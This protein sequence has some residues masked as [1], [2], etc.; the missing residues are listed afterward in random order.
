MQINQHEC[1]DYRCD[2]NKEEEV[3]HDKD[4]RVRFT[5]HDKTWENIVR[6]VLFAVGHSQE[7][8]GI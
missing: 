3:M 2:I 5:G 1:G 8:E 7:R 4:V 6:A